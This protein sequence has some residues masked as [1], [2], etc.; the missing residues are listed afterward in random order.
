MEAI[1]AAHSHGGAA[2]SSADMAA[3]ESSPRL[4]S[5]V[6]KLIIPPI[7]CSFPWKNHPDYKQLTVMSDAW[8]LAQFS[9]MHGAH[10]RP[11]SFSADHLINSA[12]HQVATLAFSNGLSP[13]MPPIIKMMDWFF[14]IDNI[15]DDPQ[16]M[17]ADLARADHLVD[18]VLTVFLGTYQHPSSS[19]SAPLVS[20]ITECAAEWWAE[21][22]QG[23]PPKL[24]ARLSKAFCDYLE[25]NR[26]QVP[27]RNSR[28]LPDV[29]TYLKIRADS[30]GWRPCAVVIE[31]AQAFELDDE[32]L[33]HPLLIALHEA[34]VQ[35]IT[36][37]NDI[38]SFKKEYM[39]G[40]FCNMV[41][42]LY[43]KKL[44]DSERV[45]AGRPE[46]TLQGAVLEV[47][48]M[49]KERDDECVRL[50][51]EI[52][53]CEKLM[54]KDGMV[55]YLEGLGLCMSGNLYWHLVSDRY[56]ICATTDI[57][58]TPPDMLAHH[59]LIINANQEASHIVPCGVMSDASIAP[60]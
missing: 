37:V 17:G 19:P 21:M 34:T 55:Q 59:H 22:C 13:R 43:F 23:M 29:E 58:V 42:I 6:H 46:P 48:K 2:A 52:G 44:Y 28:H 56:G 41:F 53:K 5:Q 14:M 33:S 30:I 18:N 38:T 20:I 49:I 8:V 15:L 31:H 16:E 36:L 51:R 39:Q 1:A 27:F 26:Q 25:A 3:N 10:G 32:A 4:L 45:E 24:K 60:S 47:V 40:D 54:G 35:H 50:M 12:F 57:H 7:P 11:S 9:N